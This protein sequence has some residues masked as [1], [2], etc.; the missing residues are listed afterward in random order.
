MTPCIYQSVVHI[1]RS[2]TYEVKELK[3]HKGLGANNTCDLV[4]HSINVL[5]VTDFY[6]YTNILIVIF[7]EAIYNSL[8]ANQIHYY[9][10]DSFIQT[11]LIVKCSH[12]EGCQGSG[13]S[14]EMKI[15]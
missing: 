2:W 8:R 1:S 6:L 10:T 4:D 13:H 12:R 5:Y 3:T 9:K 15:N 14:I 11:L 7:L